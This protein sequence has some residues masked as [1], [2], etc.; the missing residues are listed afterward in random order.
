MLS[1]VSL[2]EALTTERL[3]KVHFLMA[4]KWLRRIWIQTTSAA[5]CRSRIRETRHLIWHT[6]IGFL[7]ARG[8]DVSWLQ[9]VTMFL[10]IHRT[11]LYYASEGFPARLKSFFLP[12]PLSLSHPL[13]GG[14]RLES[15][16][17]TNKAY[18]R[19][20]EGAT[21]SAE[22]REVPYHKRSSPLKILIAGFT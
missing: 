2:N 1:T 13:T 12:S 4:V 9:T 8:M 11:F 20:T 5:E 10:G 18:K 21:G 16:R 17:A 15:E 3:V 7:A 14:L 6:L 22:L 19:P